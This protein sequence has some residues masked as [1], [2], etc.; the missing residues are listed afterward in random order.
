MPFAGV[1]VMEQP[2]TG[3]G[4]DDTALVAFLNHQIIPDR[5]AGLGNV[6]NT[7]SAGS[8]DIVCKGEERIGV[9]GNTVNFIQKFPFFHR[10]QRL[11]PV[12]KVVLP[13]A[14]SAY[15]LFVAIDVAISYV[16]PVGAAQVLPEGQMQRFWV[17]P[18]KAG[19][20]LG[21]CQAGAVNPGLLPSTHTNGLT[22]IGEWVYFKVIKDVRRS[23]FAFSGRILFFVTMFCS[24]FS[25]IL[26]LFRL[27]WKVTPNTVLVSCSAGA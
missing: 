8:L 27:C 15:I 20:R 14:V 10:R 4:H 7:G 16:I 17:L 2:H 6:G 24:I 9:Q 11:R 1:S 25:S 21:A 23:I 18:Q 26:K 12:G 19:I 13:D 22:I 5:A 3:E